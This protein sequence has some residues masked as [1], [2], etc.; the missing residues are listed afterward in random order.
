MPH[1]DRITAIS[2]HFARPNQPPAQ[3]PPPLADFWAVR[4]APKDPTLSMADRWLIVCM[5]ALCV[6]TILCMVKSTP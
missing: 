1:L 3:K 5:A 6:V 4:P 2:N